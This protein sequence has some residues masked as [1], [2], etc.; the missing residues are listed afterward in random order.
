VICQMAALVRRALAEI[1]D[2]PVFLVYTVVAYN[3]PPMLGLGGVATTWVG[4]MGGESSGLWM[5]GGSHLPTRGGAWEGKIASNNS[6]NKAIEE[7]TYFARVVH[8]HHPHWRRN[9][10][11]AAWMVLSAA[12][13]RFCSGRGFWGTFIFIL[14]HQTGQK[15]NKI[16][17]Q[18]KQ[19]Q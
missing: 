10:P 6:V 13:W 3:S 14:I 7:I 9:D 4:T 16:N 8:F 11:S 12:K 19:V 15:I 5:W 1:C 18:N 17:K 2:V